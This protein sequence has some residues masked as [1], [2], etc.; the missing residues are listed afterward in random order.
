MKMIRF[1]GCEYRA[2]VPFDPKFIHSNW[3]MA[4]LKLGYIVRSLLKE[5]SP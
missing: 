1:Q 5:N 4:P 2:F 3:K